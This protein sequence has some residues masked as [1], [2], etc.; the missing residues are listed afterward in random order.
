MTLICKLARRK[1]L[2]IPIPRHP[3]RLTSKHSALKAQR[4]RARKHHL[5]WGCLELIRNGLVGDWV[6][7][8]VVADFEDAV[9]G[10]VC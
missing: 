3:N 4:R 2:L 6:C 5:A 10:R 8:G 7:G 9:A 1:Q